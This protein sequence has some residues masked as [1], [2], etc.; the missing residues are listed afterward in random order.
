MILRT[1][2]ISF[3]VKNNHITNSEK[4]MK[5]T[6]PGLYVIGKTQ[7]KTIKQQIKKCTK[8]ALLLSL[9]SNL[10]NIYALI[11]INDD[12]NRKTTIHII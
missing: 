12:D 11:F 5:R 1:T 2:N 3:K 4:T 9:H 6:Q 8:T 7:E 10:H